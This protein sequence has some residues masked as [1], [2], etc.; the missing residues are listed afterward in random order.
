MTPPASD[1]K[2]DPAPDHAPDP[3]LAIARFLPRGI[4]GQ[5]SA[6]WLIPLYRAGLRFQ[7][8]LAPW[9]DL[10]NG[11]RLYVHRPKEITTDAL[12][13]LLW[14][15]GGGLVIGGP[16]IDD[17]FCADLAERLGIIVAAASYRLAPEHP[18]P[19]AHDDL[20]AAYA[21]LAAVPQVD[22]ARIALGGDSAGGGLAA[23]LAVALC[24]DP[25]TRP[26][27]LLLHEPMLDEATRKTTS[28]HKDAR[29]WSLACNRFG[30][31][32]YLAGLS[33]PIPATASAARADDATLARF[34]PCWLGVGTADLF[35][36]EVLEFAARL[37]A[38]GV[39]AEVTE[40]PGG[41]HG[42]NKTIPKAVL[43]KTY[44]AAMQAALAKGLGISRA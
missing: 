42:F 4:F 25:A 15:H 43:T 22:P 16:T 40:A 29:I 41:F 9:L 34:P 35:H 6:R 3:A 1:P 37:T 28:I 2:F 44:M 14:V 23:A 10:P 27:F 21:A 17:A 32:S 5:R 13:A 19:A 11:Q 36:A 18:Y 20:K 12:P 30:W 8:P 38:C 39:K 24:D 7:R 33:G 31:D 26:A